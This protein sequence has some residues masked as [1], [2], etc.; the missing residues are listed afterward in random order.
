MSSHLEPDCEVSPKSDT[1]VWEA[2]WNSAFVSPSL[3]LRNDGRAPVCTSHNETY[4]AQAVLRQGK[5]LD[6][7]THSSRN[8]WGNKMG[9]YYEREFNTK[10]VTRVNGLDYA[11]FYCRIV[12]ECSSCS[13]KIIN[14]G[15]YHL[16]VWIDYIHSWSLKWS[17]GVT[18]GKSA[19]GC[20]LNSQN[21]MGKNIVIPHAREMFFGGKKWFYES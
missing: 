17:W 20:L 5:T 10:R 3:L 8:M 12:A 1:E 18:S 21:I 19:K 2:H 7:H 11:A 9:G 14:I 16:D 6:T 13:A 15:W 4:G